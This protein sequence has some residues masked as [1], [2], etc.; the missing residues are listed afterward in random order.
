MNKPQTHTAAPP[1]PPG[2][3]D[4]LLNKV[5]CPVCKDPDPDVVED[6]A[7]GDLICR[8]CGCVIGDRIVDEHS[9]WRTF[10]N[11]ESTGADPNRV[12]G[13]NNPLL[14]EGGLSTV[15]GKGTGKDASVLSRMQNRGALGSGDRSLLAAFK[16][17][18]K[19]S[20]H[21]GLPQTVQ[22]TAK[23]LF[24]QMD[25]R[26]PMKGKSAD[27]ML[28]ASL[29]MACRIDGIARTFK[30]VC[31]LSN[32]VSKKELAKCYKQMRE[33]LGDVHSL[34]AI[35]TDDFMTRF[36][37]NLSLP[38]DVKKAADH[39][40]RTAIDLGIVAGKNPLSVTAAAIYLVS[41]LSADKRTQKAISDVSGVSEVTI[42][43]V[44]KDL[45]SKRDSL[46][47]PNSP[48]LQNVSDLPST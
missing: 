28:A 39:V 22:D 40:S 13:P 33:A 8:R 6:Y 21:I 27:G 38:N 46:L 35:S 41:Q 42:R 37:S 16:E 14:R 23:E 45:Y 31:A 34:H 10:S 25:D 15:I 18:E 48:F 20:D 19:M 17:I 47:P 7:R 32:N 5:T 12:G 29:Y 30:E 24:R 36:C 43:N 26:K 11:S 1:L 44:Y 2:K 3:K 9:E 4:A